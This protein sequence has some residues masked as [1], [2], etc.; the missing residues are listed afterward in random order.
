MPD[1]SQKLQLI[2][3]IRQ[4]GFPGSAT[5][6]FSAYDQGR[7][8]IG[9]F[10]AQQQQQ[11]E[12]Q[13]QQQSQQ[14]GNQ[15]MAQ[16]GPPQPPPMNRPDGRV[17]Q[18]NVNQPVDNNQGHLVQ[19]GDTQNVGIQDLPTGPA[20][21]QMIQA[22][23][24]GV[25]KYRAGGVKK[26][27]P[28]ISKYSNG[29]GIFRT[30][31][32]KKID[33]ANK[34][35]LEG[36]L[37]KTP[38]NVVDDSYSEDE[39][40]LENYSEDFN[41]NSQYAKYTS[42]LS[43]GENSTVMSQ[44]MY[45]ENVKR[46]GVDIA[47]QMYMNKESGNANLPTGVV[48]STSSLGFDPYSG[49]FN[50]IS[51]LNKKYNSGTD[52]PE[53]YDF[54]TYDPNFLPP[55]STGEINLKTTA[56][57]APL[58]PDGKP[59]TGFAYENYDNIGQFDHLDQDPSVNEHGLTDTEMITANNQ[60]KYNSR[61]GD[62]TTIKG[63]DDGK[64][65]QIS[66]NNYMGNNYGDYLNSQKSFKK[67]QMS[68]AIQ[69]GH[70]SFF[71]T[72]GD[73]AHE[74]GTS[75]YRAAK[76]AYN[77]PKEAALF[78]AD[79]LAGVMTVA[80]EPITTGIGGAWLT[81]RGGKGLWD[82]HTKHKSNPEQYDPIGLNLQ[83]AGNASYLIPGLGATGQV[84][85]K[86]A[87][88]IKNSLKYTANNILKGS[89]DVVKGAITPVTKMPFRQTVGYTPPNKY[90][91][92]FDRVQN[93]SVG[94]T[95]SNNVKKTYKGVNQFVNPNKTQIMDPIMKRFGTNQKMV[96]KFNSGP[97]TG[98][99]GNLNRSTTGVSYPAGSIN[100]TFGNVTNSIKGGINAAYY[101]TKVYGA[102]KGLE[103]VYNHSTTPSNWNNLDSNLNFGTDLANTVFG[104]EKV[105]DLAKIGT[106]TGLGKY[107]KA[108]TQAVGM[109]PFLKP[110][111][112]S[113]KLYNKTD[114]NKGG[115]VNPNA[116]SIVSK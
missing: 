63:Y 82:Q 96:T 28:Y 9:E 79:L 3:A 14:Q 49:K 110:L 69:D 58:G 24:G 113:N 100:N 8:L 68:Q 13:E 92:F 62:G 11:Q 98:Y 16:G 108:I 116:T 88:L 65:I 89:R 30:K 2:Q 74:V 5:D 45:E 41:N 72:V 55:N 83:T 80:P 50:N 64:G 25:K 35:I 91:N 53:G 112:N 36:N 87:P 17:S 15:G 38:T 60:I 111:A 102:K 109:F 31:K 12:Q 61:Y 93:T 29:G 23:E 86:S 54:N 78:G 48:A 75:P 1:N 114:P 44:A 90:A 105:A 94:R 21:S 101:G 52:V 46:H 34:Q 4:S 66:N 22:R 67:N 43:V 73:M 104:G 26:A 32:Q 33:E 76:Y 6:V 51:Y 85:K 37:Y 47:N 107:N 59:L 97:Q 77:N 27:K 19:A 18:P 81:Y 99:Y 7:D 20:Q 39:E 106:Y 56:H 103:A 71:N 84:I 95:F 40:W 115:T 10:V 57:N 42:G 70:S